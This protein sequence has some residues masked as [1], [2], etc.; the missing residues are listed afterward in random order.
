MLSSYTNQVDDSYCV[1]RIGGNTSMR[2]S[3]DRIATEDLALNNDLSAG[4]GFLKEKLQFGVVASG[5]SA[6]VERVAAPQDDRIASTKSFGSEIVVDTIS[7]S[8]EVES[9]LHGVSANYR[10]GNIVEF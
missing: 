8:C 9:V 6:V 1:G 2:V 3:S 10:L 4:V 7:L 5:Q